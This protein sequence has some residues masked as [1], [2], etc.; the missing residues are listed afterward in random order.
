M[1]PFQV[2]LLGPSDGSGELATA[3]TDQGAVIEGRFADLHALRTRWRPGDGHPRLFVLRLQGD[4][5]IDVLRE[6]NETFPGFPLLALVEGTC[7][8]PTLFQVSRAGAAQLLPFPVQVEDVQA[9][10]DT[11]L[12]QFGWSRRVGKLIAVSA[13]P[14]GR[15]GA[16]FAV[17]LASEI[18]RTGADCILAEPGARLGR[19]LTHLDT[20]H[21]G[22]V[23]LTGRPPPRTLTALLQALV[24]V[25]DHL[26]VLPGPLRG[27][28][29][30]SVETS[31]LLQLIDLLRQSTEVVVL[32]V[33]LTFDEAYFETLSRAEYALLLTEQNVPA[34]HAM[35]EIHDAL[36]A[37]HPAGVVRV[38]LNHF[39]VAM[40]GFE[41]DRIRELLAAEEVWTVSKDE[42]AWATVV[43]TGR[44]LRTHS[45][46]SAALADINR[47]VRHLL[48]DKP[49]GGH[50]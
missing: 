36:A 20:S 26:R 38:V 4:K 8:T 1:Y 14:E 17:N 44:L 16:A 10:L 31:Q 39:D 13:V 19:L 45:S 7:D 47:I 28:A 12:R 27:V 9:A 33:P 43:N 23:T 35:R 5:D 32:D 34:L 25:A 3:L 50:K 24:P 42:A 48:D 37:R 11:L 18:A 29:T 6:L 46:R 40:A 49:P 15:D 30:Q 2:I 21:I 22:P 41:P